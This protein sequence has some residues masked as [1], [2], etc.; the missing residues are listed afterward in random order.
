MNKRHMNKGVQTMNKRHMNRWIHAASRALSRGVVALGALAFLTVSVPAAAVTLSVNTG[1]VI[2]DNF[3]GVNAVYHGT[4]SLP[5]ANANGMTDALRTIEYDRVGGMNLHIARSWYRPQYTYGNNYYGTPDWNTTNMTALYSWLQEMKD[6][7]IEVALQMG[8]WFGSDLYNGDG[9]G[10]APNTTPTANDI[11]NFKHWVSDSLNQIVNVKGFTNVKY[12]VMFT[13]GN[14]DLYGPAP[15]GYS[16]V[17]SG[18]AYYKAVVTAVHEQLV[19]DG[20][21][22]LV[23]IVAGET[24]PAPRWVENIRDELASYCDI[25]SSHEYDFAGGAPQGYSFWY[26]IAANIRSK[27]GALPYWFD[28]YG[29][30]D[31]TYR[32]TADYG[33]FLAQANA[34]F[35][36]AGA[37]TSLL[38]ILMDQQYPYPIEDYGQGAS[39]NSTAEWVNGI[40][41]WGLGNWLPQNRT[42]RP[43]WYS[44][45]LMSKYLGGPGTKVY[46]TT[47]SGGIYISATKPTSNDWTVMVVNGNDSAQDITVNCTGA[48]NKTL[49]RYL[50]NPNTIAPTSDAKLIGY[51]CV[52]SN[53]STRLD[54]TMPAKGVAIYSSIQGSAEPTP[55]PWSGTV[56]DD[57][58]AV[59]Y[60]GAWTDYNTRTGAY[61]GDD[62]YT[63]TANAYAQYTFVGTTVNY[64]A[65]KD[66]NL[67]N[68]D[69]YVD[70]SLE[71]T[72]DMYSSTQQLQKVLFTKTGLTYGSHTIRVVCKGTKNASSSGTYIDLDAFM[73]APATPPSA[74][75]ASASSVSVPEGGTNTFQVSLSSQP[76]GDVVVAVAWVSGDTN[77]TVTDGANLTFT[78]NN[79]ATYQTVTLA[80]SKDADAVNGAATITCCGT[81][82]TSNRVVAT[83][84]DNDTTLTVSTGTGGTVSPSGAA[85]VT[86]GVATTINAV[87]AFGYVFENWTV[88]SGAATIG[89]TNATNTTVMIAAPATVQATFAVEVM[90]A[91]TAPLNGAVLK[92]G[93]DV[94][95]VAAATARGAT[96]D[97]VEFFRDGV[98]L[99]EDENSPYTW[100]WTNVAVGAYEL[101]ARAVDSLG[102]T[103][104][105]AAVSVQVKTNGL[106][107]VHAT[108][109]TV[110]NYT[111]S[112]GTNWRVHVFTTGMG[113]TNFNVTSGG[114]VEVLVV[115]GGGGGG[116]RYGGGGGAGGLIYS[117]AFAVTNNGV[118]AVTVGGGGKGGESTMTITAQGGDGTNSVFGPLIAN[119]GGGGGG[120][121]E[122]EVET[123]GR[124]GGSGGGEAHHFGN[125]AIGLADPAGQG[126][127]GGGGEY[128]GGGGAGSVGVSNYPGTGGVGRAYSIS[129]TN[130]YYAGGGGGLLAPGGLGG[131]GAGGNSS[132]G[133]AATV[134][135]GGG[136]G[137][138]HLGVGGN[139]GSGIVI[140]RY[141]SG[142]EPVAPAAPAGFTATAAATNQIN[143]VWSDN[144]TNETGY[145]VHRSF[146]SND[147]VLVVVTSAN[148]TNCIDTGLTTNTLYYYRVAASNEAGL[149]AYCFATGMTWSVYEAWRHTQFDATALTN[150][151]IS[152][153]A[154]DPDHDGLNNVQEFL[155]GTDPTNAASVLALF[156]PTV[157]PGGTGFVVSWQSA[158]N[159]FYTL[160]TTTNLVDPGFADRVKNI[161]ATPM[162]NVYTDTFDSAGQKFYRVKLE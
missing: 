69:V 33:N 100:A 107:S 14:T 112:G 74:I 133:A 25:V 52:F 59:M 58:P 15:S 104:D 106:G 101:M 39:W 67:G 139:G 84:A 124:D 35:I 76:T 136:G 72:V 105:A 158:S 89:D 99:G 140:V 154:A 8:W 92:A 66:A 132:Y 62:H 94:T 17:N 2:Q 65:M 24:H 48:I 83:E 111:D 26:N 143:L 6:R 85:V 20:T 146:D 10:K 19:T 142:G 28:E 118:Y 78:T 36:N 70:S 45:A 95:I 102:V 37:Q 110:T 56:N 127:N 114:Y 60:S 68:V 87:P 73:G 153:D 82:W 47:N 91:I 156:M 121:G 81:G 54:D 21:H 12:I 161:F 71:A 50:Y 57:D 115:A 116:G 148:A 93:T 90:C 51:D 145:V 150:A 123:S 155:A 32:G 152:G 13:E 38:W 80:A 149:S 64:I 157:V 46:Q 125:S 88:A 55:D 4:S 122:H 109:G 160:Q 159:K 16:T 141:V 144:A 119:K 126:N 131:G 117:N 5:E 41:R 11:G 130:T 23:K 129:G 53:V 77:I 103:G 138:G 151:A 162:L 18:W 75:L 30:F 27:C 137:G 96:V 108:G 97:K 44:F 79:W 61:N 147:W 113:L 22:D 135:T 3:L 49:Y 34:A 128:G 29:N 134:N 40:Q 120:W 42:P 43:G 86:K 7:N 63:D 1:A 98:K 9:L 31:I